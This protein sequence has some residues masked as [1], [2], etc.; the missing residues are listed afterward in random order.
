VLGLVAPAAGKFFALPKLHPMG[1]QEVASAIH[2]I[3]YKLHSRPT[4]RRYLD[5]AKGQ[6]K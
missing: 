6:G 2:V 3:Q 5:M 4:Y 1:A